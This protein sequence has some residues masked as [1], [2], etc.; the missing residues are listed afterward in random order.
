MSTDVTG[1]GTA[2]IDLDNSAASRELLSAFTASG[3]FEVVRYAHSPTELTNLLD[4]GAVRATIHF[5]A[6]F[7]RELL[8]GRT[9]Q[10]Q[11]LADGTDSNSTSII[12]GYANL[13]IANFINDKLANELGARLGSPAPA[14]VD[15]ETRAWYNA[16]LESKFFFVP[17]L[18]AVMVLV[19]SM[20]LTSVAIV[21]EKEVGTIEQ[22][23]VTPISRFEFILGKTIP[24]A[25]VGYIV[26]TMQL[27]L[28]LLVFGIRV[29]GSWLLLYLLTGIYLLGNLG[30]ALLISVSAQTQ[31]Q[32]VLTAFLFMMPCVLLSGFIFPIDNMPELI[33]YATLLNPV[34]WY[35]EILRG[36]VIKGVGASVLWPAI[37]GQSLL[38]VG[39]ILLA[40]WRFRKTLV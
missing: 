36:V 37:I 5:P 10:V 31:Q 34:R 8:A 18:I 19:I 14:S 39:F 6:G 15:F 16:N 11:V 35:I 21:R 4:R 1:S 26:M 29:E 17:A 32:A 2:E 25:I 9:P 12:F 20:I 13:I 33:Q 38:A 23:M 24:F 22:V 30:L 3:Y 7:E 40:A 27:I 28:A